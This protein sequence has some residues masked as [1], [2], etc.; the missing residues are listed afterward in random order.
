LNVI[1]LKLKGSFEMPHMGDL[2]GS[3][4]YDV[5]QMPNDL[6]SIKRSFSEL[7]DD[8]YYEGRKR[9]FSQYIMFYEFSG[10]N[11]KELE[12]RPFIQSKRFNKKVGGVRRNFESVEKFDPVPYFSAIANRLDLNKDESYQVNF[13]NWRTLVGEGYTGEIV[14]EGAHRDG[15]H[16]TSVTIWDRYNIEGGESQVF[17]IAGRELQFQTT[18]NDG[19]CLIMSDA[20]VIHGATDI[21]A[22]N[23]NLGYRDTW[24]ISMNPW[25]DRRYG[26]NFEERATAK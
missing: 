19:Q 6:E 11:A 12:T 23:G 15:H 25:N 20:D 4:G 17:S 7:P 5:I 1:F 2:L 16:I 26:A 18:L 8:P 14:P 24:V 10:W 9:R 3:D 13:H 22:T 21:K